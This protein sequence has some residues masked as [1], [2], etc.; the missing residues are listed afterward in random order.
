MVDLCLARACMWASIILFRWYMR[1]WNNSEYHYLGRHSMLFTT[2]VIVV[3]CVQSEDQQLSYSHIIFLPSLLSL[4]PPPLKKHV[5][6]Q[7]KDKEV[8][9][10]V[11]WIKLNPYSFDYNAF[12]LESFIELIFLFFISSFDI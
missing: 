8:W 12:G 11:C 7:K 2:P 9:F 3:R 10:F 6:L 4:S 5:A 1:C